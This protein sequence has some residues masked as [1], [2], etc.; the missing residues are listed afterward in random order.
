MDIHKRWYEEVPFPVTVCDQNGIIVVMN[1]KSIAQFENDGGADLIG[2]S[3]LN[4][5]PEPARSMLCKMLESQVPHTYISES[6]GKTMINHE[7]PWFID[8]EY[9]GFVEISLELPDSIQIKGS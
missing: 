9:R 6:D 8:G 5:H 1:Q 4:C 7:T 3:L 2:K